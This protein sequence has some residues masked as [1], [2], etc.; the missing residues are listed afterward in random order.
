MAVRRRARA[1]PHSHSRWRSL[2]TTGGLNRARMSE[3]EGSPATSCGAGQTAQGS[4]RREAR[5]EKREA[6]RTVRRERVPPTSALHREG[7]IGWE[8]RGRNPR[9][10]AVEGRHNICPPD[11]VLVRT[12]PTRQRRERRGM[13][14]AEEAAEGGRT[15][16]PPGGGSVRTRCVRGV[17]GGS[18]PCAGSNSSYDP[19]VRNPK[20]TRQRT[21]DAPPPDAP[22]VRTS[23]DLG[24]PGD[25]FPRRHLRTC[26]RRGGGRRPSGRG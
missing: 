15:D 17:P 4:G 24:V 11:G 2:V 13:Q 12:T 26:S 6:L 19:R 22:V 20:A 1:L 21:A 7:R 23:C 5:S 14:L 3:K 9:E 18:T 10:P 25:S 16:W 8:P